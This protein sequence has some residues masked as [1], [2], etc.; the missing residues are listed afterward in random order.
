MRR[1]VLLAAALT[2]AACGSMPPPAEP[3]PPPPPE[4]EPV[5]P[6]APAPLALAPTFAANEGRL[7]WPADGTVVGFF[8]QRRDPETGTLTEAVGIDVATA[9]GEA[10]RAAFGGRVT[11][12]GAMAAFGTYVMLKHDGFTTVYGNLSRVDVSQGDTLSVGA[13][14]GAAGTRDERRGPRLFFAVFEGETA[15]DPLRWLRPRTASDTP[16][17][18]DAP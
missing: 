12:V 1:F 14:V 6:Q 3:P 13:L 9:P 11:R 4:P 2:L 18:P 17:S 10:V 5:A 7:P 16:P 15:V 8:G